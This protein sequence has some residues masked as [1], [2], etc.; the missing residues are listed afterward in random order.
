MRE[1]EIDEGAEGDR[2]RYGGGV[3]EG[4]MEE[5]GIGRNI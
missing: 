3:I 5:G 2:G 4:D 1:I